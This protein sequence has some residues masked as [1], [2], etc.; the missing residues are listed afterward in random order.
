[1]SSRDRPR[2]FAAG[3]AMLGLAGGVLASANLA[4][5]ERGKIWTTRPAAAITGRRSGADAGAR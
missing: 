1:M 2:S 5:G 3:L 4:V